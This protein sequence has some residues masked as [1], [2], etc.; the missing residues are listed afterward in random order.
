MRIYATSACRLAAAARRRL[1]RSLILRR[2]H[3]QTFFQRNFDEW[4]GSVALKHKPSG[5]FAMGNL[6]HVP[7]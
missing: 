3:K 4:A 6:Q 7:I 5:L 1:F 2:R